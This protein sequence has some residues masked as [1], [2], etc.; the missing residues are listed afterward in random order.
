M[1]LSIATRRAYK[2]WLLGLII[3]II[4]S[5]RNL[6]N[7]SSEEAK[8][9]YKKT[10]SNQEGGID[11]AKWKEISAKLKQIKLTSILNLIKNI[12]DSITAS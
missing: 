1:D 2:F 4:Y 6:M 10:K 8:L 5:I 3:G 9:M 7:A 12:G 11:E